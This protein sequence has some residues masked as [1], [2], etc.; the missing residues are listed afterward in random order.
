MTGVCKALLVGVHQFSEDP[1][2]LLPLQGPPHDVRALRAALS[3]PETGLFAERDITSVLDPTKVD[4][5]RA[6]HDFFS[7]GQRGDI[8]LFYFSGHGRLT[9]DGK[10]FLC[11]SDSATARIQ[12]TGIAAATLRDCIEMSA[13]RTF[14]V[15]LDCCHSGAFRGSPIPLDGLGGSG[16]FFLAS[17]RARQLADDG[18]GRG[19]SPFTA[20]IVE[21]LRDPA[22]DGD[23]D[24]WITFDDVYR[25]AYARLASLRQ[26][27]QRSTGEGTVVLACGPAS[28]G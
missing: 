16:T 19:A 14:V 25:V 7:A 17:S 18:D 28:A 27:P 1:E 15:I 6:M 4:A 22:S 11:A 12:I 5:E 20:A 26:F 9:R 3:N 24:G 23:G 21:A 13:A 2:N 8:L 10:L